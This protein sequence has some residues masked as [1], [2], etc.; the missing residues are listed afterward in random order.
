MKPAKSTIRSPAGRS[1][2][3]RLQKER[4]GSR[5]RHHEGPCSLDLVFSGA[6][7]YV[8]NLSSGAKSRAMRRR[9]IR[10]RERRRFLVRRGL[11]TAGERAVCHGL[12]VGTEDA[13]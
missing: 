1:K 11:G 12:T 10:F 3:R 6:D 9:H 2:E 5:C 4:A 13:P 8:R 7:D